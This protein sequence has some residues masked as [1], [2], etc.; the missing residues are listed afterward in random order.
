MRAPVQ[1]D[2]SFLLAC[3]PS[4]PFPIMTQLWHWE[5][6]LLGLPFFLGATWTPGE[7][8]KDRREKKKSDTQWTLYVSKIP[9]AGQGKKTAPGKDHCITQNGKLDITQKKSY[10]T[11]PLACLWSP[12]PDNREKWGGLCLLPTFLCQPPSVTKA[13]I[14]AENKEWKRRT[15]VQSLS[16]MGQAYFAKCHRELTEWLVG[17]HSWEPHRASLKDKLQNFLTSSRINLFFC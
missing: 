6:L 15:W 11:S 8:P 9:S 13:R 2:P 3:F 17:F 12:S 4:I 14:L 7:M 1:P 5:V 16:R 10:G